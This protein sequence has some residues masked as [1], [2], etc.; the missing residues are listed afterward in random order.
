MFCILGARRYNGYLALITIISQ[1]LLVYALTL[2]KALFFLVVP[3]MQLLP[4]KQQ[5]LGATFY[6]RTHSSKFFN[7][8]LGQQD[9]ATDADV[10]RVV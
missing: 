4:G 3:D 9:H 8:G 10:L 6:P 1:Q 2:H 7:K 5:D